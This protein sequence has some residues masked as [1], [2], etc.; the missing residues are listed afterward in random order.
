MLLNGLIVGATIYHLQ[1]PEL[2][3]DRSHERRES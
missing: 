1:L 3:H 2:Q